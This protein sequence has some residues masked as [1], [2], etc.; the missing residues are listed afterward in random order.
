[1]INIFSSSKF[2]DKLKV[3][4]VI[5]YE[6]L[7]QGHSMMSELKTGEKYIFGGENNFSYQ[8][9]PPP[10]GK[11]IKE[12]IKDYIPMHCNAVQNHIYE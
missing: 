8:T 1:M 4:N 9:A 5:L 3:W 2:E 6:V 10:I 7:I 12:K 11:F